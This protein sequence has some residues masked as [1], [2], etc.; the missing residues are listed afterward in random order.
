M[1]AEHLP[2]DREGYVYRICDC[3]KERY[4]VSVNRKNIEKYIC[5]ICSNKMYRKNTERK[6]NSE[7]LRKMQ[8]AS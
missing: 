8:K 2:S 7:R 1:I 4:S 6:K 3:C 5:P